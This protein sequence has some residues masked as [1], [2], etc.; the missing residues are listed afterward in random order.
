[1]RE[2]KIEGT[3][4]NVDYWADK[5]EDMFLKECGKCGVFSSYTPGKKTELL[6]IAFKLINAYHLS[7]TKKPGKV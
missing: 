5:S 4:F 6:K 3:A 2:I 7:T 1:M